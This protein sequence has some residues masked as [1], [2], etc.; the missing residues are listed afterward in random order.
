VAPLVYCI[1]GADNNGQAWN[2]LVPDQTVFTTQAYQVST[3]PIVAIQAEVPVVGP[4]P[5]GLSVVTEKKKVTAIP[6]YVWAIGAKVR[7]RSGCQPKPGR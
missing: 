1:E 6:Y 5:D 2:L 4:S 7:C 3:E